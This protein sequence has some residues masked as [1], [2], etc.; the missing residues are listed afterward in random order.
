MVIKEVAENR[1]GQTKKLMYW[2][3][4]GKHI[5]TCE[6]PRVLEIGSSSIP[7]RVKDLIRRGLKIQYGKEIY[8][9]RSTE[10]RLVSCYYMLPQDQLAAMERRNIKPEQLW[11]NLIASVSLL[12]YANDISYDITDKWLDDVNEA[13][14][15]FE[16]DKCYN[17]RNSCHTD[18]TI[19]D[20][21]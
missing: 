4:S 1:V 6:S 14:A 15:K 19:Q 10:S 9:S 5:N 21:Q 20:E 8:V 16:A 18:N 13:S 11:T 2:L 7:R 12:R 3:L 17:M